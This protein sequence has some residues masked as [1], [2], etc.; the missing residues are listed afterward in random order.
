[1][2]ITKLFLL[3]LLLSLRLSPAQVLSRTSSRISGAEIVR[4]HCWLAVTTGVLESLR[5]VGR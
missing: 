2:Q 4:L 3:L 5:G 1:M